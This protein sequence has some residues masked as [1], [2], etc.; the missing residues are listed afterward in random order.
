[1]KQLDLQIILPVYNEARGIEQVIR[2]IQTEIGKRIRME[3][4]ISE[5]GSTDG[6]KQVLQ[7]LQGDISMILLMS[8]KRK[9]YA[10]AMIDA[11]KS[12]RAPYILSL[13]SDGQCDP[14]DF[15]KFWNERKKFDV[16]I[17]NRVKRE[18]ALLRRALSRFFYICYKIIFRLPIHDPSCPYV[19]MTKDVSIKL[20]SD[21]GRM[22]E[23]FWWEFIATV[24]TYGYKV[25]EVPVH[26]RA[27]IF[28]KT[29][30]YDL[31]KLPGIGIRHFI[32]LYSMWKMARRFHE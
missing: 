29:K 6:T 16:I 5:D 31:H 7:K 23:G 11:M 21:L 9:G 3:F 22:K 18:D 28:G 1:M 19:L 30:I 20:S 10:R 2:E 17:G 27:R 32:A 13:D 12:V 14:K 8:K 26:H 4:I 25:K 24:F 15:M